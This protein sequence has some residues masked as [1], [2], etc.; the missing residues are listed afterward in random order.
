MQKHS[1]FLIKKKKKLFINLNEYKFIIHFEQMYYESVDII[2]H[3]T[4]LQ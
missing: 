2:C 1:C 4:I 3:L